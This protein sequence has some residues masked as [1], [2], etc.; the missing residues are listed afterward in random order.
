MRATFASA[1]FGAPRFADSFFDVRF[2][3]IPVDV[4]QNPGIVKRAQVR[5]IAIS[6]RGE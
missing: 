3:A 1:F 2:V 6:S 5:A 4:L